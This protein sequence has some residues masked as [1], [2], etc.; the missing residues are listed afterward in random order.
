MAGKL[1]TIETIIMR[2]KCDKINSIKSLNL[3]GNDL[4]DISCVSSVPYLEVI[5]LAVNKI[6][7]LKPFS[8]LMYLR[9]LYMRKNNISSFS[10]IEYLKGCQS[11]KT[12]TLN[13]NPISDNPN[14]RKLVIRALPQLIKLDDKIISTEEMNQAKDGDF[15][16][17]AD[18][19][20]DYQ[21][22]E[23][24]VSN[25]YTPIINKQ[26]SIKE[27]VVDNKRGNFNLLKKQ[28]D[29]VMQKGKIDFNWLVQ[30]REPSYSHADEDYVSA[31]DRKAVG[32]QKATTP[33]PN[34]DFTSAYDRRV[35]GGQ[36][37]QTP[38]QPLVHNKKAS[39]R[40]EESPDY[41]VPKEDSEPQY[42]KVSQKRSL[43]NDELPNIVDKEKRRPT[44]YDQE[45]TYYVKS[46]KPSQVVETKYAQPKKT[47][48]VS[49]NSD[50]SPVIKPK[51]ANRSVENNNSK[52]L[53]AIELLCDELSRKDLIVLYQSIENRLVKKKPQF[54]EDDD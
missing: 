54:Y 6:R 26:A 41:Y 40:K 7:T 3:W 8:K 31:Y 15:D 37:Q 43:T 1:L 9:E 22:Q 12:L 28:S 46:N 29:N 14:Y 34:E 27:N 24:E 25:K 35:V 5:S 33:Q 49:D 17:E 48:K 11:L 20:D 36:K 32:G 51:Q 44:A 19:D 38:T 2:T 16:V 4:E 10:E 52:I 42:S 45:E 53:S 50:E 23:E 47:Q 30:Q 13:E 21:E 39:L 18:E